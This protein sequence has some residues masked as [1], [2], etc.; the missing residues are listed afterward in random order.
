MQPISLFLEFALESY[1]LGLVQEFEEIVR[2]CLR[3]IDEKPDEYRTQDAQKCILLNALIS[4][5][6]TI[7]RSS[8]GNPKLSEN[9]IIQ[10]TELINTAAKLKRKDPLTHV[11]RGTPPSF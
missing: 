3:T 4:H 9:A 7:A 6:L 10:A 1:K 5:F 11:H 2:L 8:K